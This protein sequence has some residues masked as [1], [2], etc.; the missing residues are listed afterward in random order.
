[1]SSDREKDIGD[2][3][4]AGFHKTHPLDRFV[5]NVVNKI[6]TNYVVPWLCECL[7]K[8][9]ES[10]FHMKMSQNFDFIQDWQINHPK[11]YHMFIRGGR[12]FKNRVN[13]DT[14]EIL[15]RVVTILEQNGW[16]VY[17]NEINKLRYTINQV[18]M[19]IYSD[20]DTI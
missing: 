19:S 5:S 18:R 2:Y 1:M 13:F 3:L 15:S 17:P 4:S 11:R 8:Y 6:L 20:F 16:H 14:D 12:K 7:V 9:S 10:E